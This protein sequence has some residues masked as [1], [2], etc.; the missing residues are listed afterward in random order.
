MQGS[1]LSAPKPGR[2]LTD[3]S[4]NFEIQASLQSHANDAA[5]SDEILILDGEVQS[6]SALFQWNFYPRWQ[7]NLELIGVRNT[8]GNLDS[9]IDGWHSAFGLDQGDRN[10]F[11]R[12]QL[13]FEYG[14]STGRVSL[15]DS[16]SGLGDVEAGLA[17]Q[18]I[19]NNKIDL[20]LNADLNI[21]VGDANDLLGSDKTDVSVSMALSSASHSAISWHANLG[22]LRIGDKTLF[23]A[24]TKSSVGFTSL[25]VH[26][27]PSKKWRWTAQLDGH[28]AVFDSAIPEL[29]QS[30]W[31]LAFGLQY[32]KHWQVYF[33][34]DISV[35]RAA[36]FSIG[37]RWRK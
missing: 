8:A 16:A 27:Q 25:G 2:L 5:G 29:N 10:L 23:G 30:A 28:Q 17:Y 31:Q 21:A 7:A 36:D 26:W 12:D 32:A 37:I 35:N 24:T 34:E 13:R 14:N 20:S 9:V 6:V 4:W 19:S 1:G 18:L 15:I 33:A 11:A 3:A 22:L